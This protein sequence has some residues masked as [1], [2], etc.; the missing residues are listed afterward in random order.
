SWTVGRAG[1]PITPAH[2]L[3]TSGN[4]VSADYFDTMGMRIVQG[5]GFAERAT[6][7]VGQTRPTEAIINQAF[8]TKFFPGSD[9]LG[10][11]FGTAV[12]GVA[13]A[14]YEVVG[15]VNDAK[16]RSLREPTT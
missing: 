12:D 13:S 1:E 8:A 3:N 16:Y 5:R 6:A 14:G 11:H 10:Q 7:N 15:V 9:P 4:T 2:F